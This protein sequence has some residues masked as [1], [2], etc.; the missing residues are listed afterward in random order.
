MHSFVGVRLV[1]GVNWVADFLSAA[2]W[3][4][5]RLGRNDLGVNYTQVDSVTNP[6][7]NAS[8][9]RVEVL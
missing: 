2:V 8:R 1:A 9:T 5:A 3:N 6:G 7:L 4:N